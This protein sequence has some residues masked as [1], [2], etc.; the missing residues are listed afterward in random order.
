MVT[1]RRA[2]TYTFAIVGSVLFLLYRWTNHQASTRPSSSSFSPS[3]SLDPLDEDDSPDGFSLDSLASSRP[4]YRP[5]AR[6]SPPQD[7]YLTEFTPSVMAPSSAMG[8]AVVD[9]LY[10]LDGVMY[11]A[12]GSGHQRMER[13]D[14]LT[15][16]KDWV[17]KGSEGESEAWWHEVKGRGVGGQRAD[18]TKVRVVGGTTVSIDT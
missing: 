4:F 3:S 15:G 7:T 6:P 2:R 5:H 9:Y 8:F 11:F 1:S 16:A 12:R 17:E 10:L 14:I 13:D 18:H